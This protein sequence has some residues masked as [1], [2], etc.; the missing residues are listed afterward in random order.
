MVKEQQKARDLSPAVNRFMYGMLILLSLY[1]AIS[2][3]WMTAASNL[4]IGLIFDP[5]DQKMKFQDRPLYQRV[6]L[7]VHVSIVFL[8]FG[9]AFSAK[10]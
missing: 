10:H 5:F 3:N 6:W 1:F 4:G 8:I 9:L 2:G 7:I